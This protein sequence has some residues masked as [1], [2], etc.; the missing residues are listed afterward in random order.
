[1]D[2][3]CSV[4]VACWDCNGG[5]LNRKGEYP[6]ARQLAVLQHANPE[7]YDLVRFNFLR[8]PN[9][10]NYV[11]QDEVDQWHRHDEHF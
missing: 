6:V 9:A 5:V 4:L 3:E 8:N 7:G 10:P 11:T 2:E 1:M